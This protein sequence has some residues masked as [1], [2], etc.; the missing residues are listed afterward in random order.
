MPEIK[1]LAGQKVGIS[2][3][4]IKTISLNAPLTP[5]PVKLNIHIQPTNGV[6]Y[7]FMYCTTYLGL[8]HTTFF[9]FK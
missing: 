5:H 9:F 4:Y 8:K 1:G 2:L 7:I 6:H 3:E